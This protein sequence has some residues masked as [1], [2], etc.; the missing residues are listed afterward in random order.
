MCKIT[1]KLVTLF[2]DME[3]KNCILHKEI[4]KQI[5]P[6]SYEYKILSDMTS[7]NLST[8]KVEFR[9]N[10][11]TEEGVKAFL[12]ELNVSS[13]CTF[14]IQSGRTDKKPSENNNRCRS[15]LRGFRKCAMNVSHSEN[16]E[17][18]QPGKNTGCPAS[19]NFRLECGVGKNSSEKQDRIYGYMLISL[20]IIL[21][22]G[23][24]SSDFRVLAKIPR[25]LS[26]T[27]LTRA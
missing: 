26:L 3:E 8:F 24:S 10:V 17:N 4:V 25:M 13:G 14:N 1:L 22:A 16:K 6:Q 19:I 18:L 9:V 5:F 20:T 2:A 27:C 15:R 21:S 23:Q 7:S 12:N 11:K